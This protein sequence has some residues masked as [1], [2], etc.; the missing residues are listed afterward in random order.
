MRLL[1]DESLPRRLRDHL[2][3]HE[4][5][6]VI[7]M[8]WGGTKNGELLRRAATE[9]D[10]FITADKQLRHQQNLAGLPVSV[11][12][13]IAN[14]NELPALLPLVPK[15]NHALGTLSP[16]TLVEVDL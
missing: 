4:V 13:L 7:D 16:R 15:L 11:V 3:D 14:S 9:F 1:L 2:P 6:T 8:G 5:S 10:A 12:V